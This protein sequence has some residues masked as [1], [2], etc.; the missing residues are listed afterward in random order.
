MFQK[1]DR[2]LDHELASAAASASASTTTLPEVMSALG[3]VDRLAQMMQAMA[4]GGPPPPP[5]QHNHTATDTSSRNV[6]F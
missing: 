3:E 1:L 2:L 6:N 5:P 4:L